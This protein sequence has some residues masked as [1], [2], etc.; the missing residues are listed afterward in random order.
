M[1][2]HQRNLVETNGSEPTKMGL[3]TFTENAYGRTVK[4]YLDAIGKEL[5]FQFQY[6]AAQETEEMLKALENY[7]AA[8]VKGIILPTFNTEEEVKFVKNMEFIMQSVFCKQ[9]RPYAKVKG[10][11]Y[12]AGAVGNDD[13]A[14]TY[15]MV[16]VLAENTV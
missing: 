5:N 16:K 10:N 1:A 7:A 15:G 13:A 11:K 4:K 8:G 6:A 12:F 2:E 14:S 9:G 3:S